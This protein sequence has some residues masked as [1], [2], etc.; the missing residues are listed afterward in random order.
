MKQKVMIV[1]EYEIEN[2][3]KVMVQCIMR[4]SQCPNESLVNS[5]KNCRGIKDDVIIIG[6]KANFTDIIEY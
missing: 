6:D 4:Q 5:I 1:S 2:G 3:L